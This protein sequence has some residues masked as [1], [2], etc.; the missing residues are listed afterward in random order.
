MTRA[1]RILEWYRTLEINVDLPA[2]IDV[3]NPYKEMSDSTYAA[4][5]EF[6]ERYYSDERPRKLLMG[7]N[8]GRLGA[9]LTGIPFTDT[10]ALESIGIEMPEVNT[11]ETSADFVWRVVEAYG[12]PEAFFGEWFIGGVSPLGFIQKN[13]KGNWV[14]FNYYDSPDVQKMLT[15]F[16]IE[17][18]QIQKELVGG[19]DKLVLFGTGKNLKAIGNLNK[20]HDWFVQIDAL[21]HPRFVMQ[22]R[23]KRIPEYLEKFVATLNM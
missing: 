9:G 11:T 1:Q 18:I 20:E 16:I 8:P 2:H 4:L 13:D 15:P 10:P 22:Y 23:R 17:Q 14:N 5:Q 6:Y 12:G 7:I 21:E 3:L 19:A